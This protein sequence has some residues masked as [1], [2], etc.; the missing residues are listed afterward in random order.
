MKSAGLSQLSQHDLWLSLL[1]NRLGK[2]FDKGLLVLIEIGMLI[3][4]DTSYCEHVFALMNR[5]KTK[6][7]NRLL[8][9]MVDHLLVMYLLGPQDGLAGLEAFMP[10]ITKKWRSNVKTKRYIS[11]LFKHQRE[12]IP[13]VDGKEL[14]NLLA[15][16]EN[17]GAHKC[18]NDE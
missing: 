4:A 12:H 16:L 14:E 7:R 13:L 8:P 9:T 17:E 1:S 5:L 10:A 6:S 15:E 18:Y 3:P 2:T 11:K